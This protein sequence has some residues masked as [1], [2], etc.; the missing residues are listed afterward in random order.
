VPLYSLIGRSFGLLARLYD[1]R[2]LAAAVARAALTGGFVL[3][4]L[5]VMLAAFGFA[6][7]AM[8]EFAAPSVGAAG[9]SLLVAGVL[10]ALALILLLCAWLAQRGKRPA[11]PAQPTIPRPAMGAEAEMIAAG[12]EAM[13]KHNKVGALLTALIAGVLAEHTRNKRR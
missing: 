8:W 1:G 5:F 9:A 11:A 4:A 10:M 13:F 7:A 6:C 2:R 3:L 12:I